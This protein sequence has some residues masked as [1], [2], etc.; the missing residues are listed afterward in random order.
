LPPRLLPARMGHGMAGRIGIHG[1]AHLVL[2]GLM[3]LG[4][5]VALIGGIVAIVRFGK[6]DGA[7]AT[8][9][10]EAFAWLFA[11]AFLAS[12]GLVLKETLNAPKA[13]H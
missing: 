9:V 10:A 12:F 6:P 8:M 3:A 11:L 7:S 2:A 4:L 5:G 13:E 1:K